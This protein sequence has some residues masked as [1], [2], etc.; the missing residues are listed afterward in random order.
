V[1]ILIDGRM[2]GFLKPTSV[3]TTLAKRKRDSLEFLSS[4]SFG[5]LT[6]DHS[7]DKAS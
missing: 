5:G 6:H 4:A 2:L 3:S 7:T 1:E